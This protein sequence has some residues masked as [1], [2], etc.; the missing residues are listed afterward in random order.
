[1]RG[2]PHGD[3][4]QVPNWVESG[5][6]DA[7]IAEGKARPWRRSRAG[8][9]RA[10]PPDSGCAGSVSRGR[11]AAAGGESNPAPRS[12]APPLA[13]E[14][15]VS[16][17]LRQSPASEVGRAAADHD[18]YRPRGEQ[19]EDRILLAIDL[20][21]TSPPPIPSSPRRPT[22][23]PSAAPS[24]ISAAGWSVSDLGDVNGDTYDDFLIGA[25]RS[26]AR[27]RSARTAARPTSSSAPRPSAS[28]PSPTGSARIDDEPL[29]YTA[30]D[31]VGD[32]GPAR[33]GGQ[34]N[35]VS[36][37]T[38]DFPFSGVTFVTTVEHPL[39]ASAPRSPAVKLGS[40]YGL[41]IGAPGGNDVNGANPGTG[42]AYL[43]SGNLSN[44][45]GQTINLDYARE[46]LGPDDRHLRQHRDRRP[47]RLLG[48]G[49]HQHL[50]RRQSATSSWVPPTR[51]SARPPA[52]AWSTAHRRRR[53][54][55]A[56]PSRPINVSTLGQ[57]G[58][59][60]SIF[61]GPRPASQA[62]FWASPTAATSTASPP[63][64]P[65][66]TTC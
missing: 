16:N 23:W 30:N 51:P 52:P 10:G 31:R 56:T 40:T 54:S 64:A 1:M 18:A 36:D 65:T 6:T 49:R 45:I 47:A 2:G 35:P 38:L 58:N 53:C 41:L 21:G 59:K 46:L 11:V 26:A 27:P 43:I 13:W 55:A 61:A 33:R 3:E 32:L 7:E 60:A 62:G 15:G 22:G 37:A 48:G 57:S 4:S 24:P 34:T 20:G 28:R 66:S 14:E 63:A 9:V 8:P 12:V 5:V 19:L 25:R 42:R 17:A 50:R 44:F 39:G 29:Q